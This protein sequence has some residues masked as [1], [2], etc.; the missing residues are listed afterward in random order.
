MWGRLGGQPLAVPYNFHWLGGTASVFLG[1]ID[2]PDQGDLKF[3]TILLAEWL[4]I[5][6]SENFL[7]VNYSLLEAT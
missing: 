5:I 6:L 3:Q 4:L 7:Q 1:G 2:A